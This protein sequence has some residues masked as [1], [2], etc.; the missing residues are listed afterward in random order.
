M[1]TEAYLIGLGD[2][3]EF[4]LGFFLVVRVLVRVP[5]HGKLPVSFLQIIILGVL[6]H[7]QYLIVIHTHL[8]LLLILLVLLV[9]LLQLKLGT[10]VYKYLLF[11]NGYVGTV[12]V[13]VVRSD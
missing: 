4:V 2:L 8:L 5:F 1:R 11:G 3:F 7:L 12:I 9:L 6:V 13:V 10:R